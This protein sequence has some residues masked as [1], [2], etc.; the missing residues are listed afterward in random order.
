MNFIFLLGSDIS[1]YI[2]RVW[3]V[4]TRTHMPSLRLEPQPPV[5][6][7]VGKLVMEFRCGLFFDMR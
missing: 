6:L 1:I 3:S 5:Q 2:V 7:M 4:N